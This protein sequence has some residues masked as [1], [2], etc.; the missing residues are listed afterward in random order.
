LVGKANK[1]LMGKD[2]MLYL[3]HTIMSHL[4][5]KCIG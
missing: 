3:P 2:L 5:V 1:N 4:V